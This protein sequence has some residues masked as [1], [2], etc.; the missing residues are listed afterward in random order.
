MFVLAKILIKR[1]FGSG[2]FFRKCFANFRKIFTK[3]ICNISMIFCN[4]CIDDECII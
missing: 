2:Y 3:S 1:V 4:I